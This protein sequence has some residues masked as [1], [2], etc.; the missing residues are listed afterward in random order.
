MTKPQVAWYGVRCPKTGRGIPLYDSSVQPGETYARGV[1]LK[2]R[3]C[4]KSHHWSRDEIVPLR[5]Q[6]VADTPTR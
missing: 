1:H 2:C 6:E 5:P 3:W 4:P